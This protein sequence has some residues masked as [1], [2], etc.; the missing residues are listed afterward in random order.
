MKKKIGVRIILVAVLLNLAACNNKKDGFDSSEKPPAGSFAYSDSNKASNYFDCDKNY[1]YY[2]EIDD[3]TMVTVFYK[4]KISSKE[5]KAEKIAEFQP[6]Q[7]ERY[8]F[9]TV[10]DYSLTVYKEYIVFFHREKRTLYKMTKDGKDFSP[11]FKEGE[12]IANGSCKIVNGRL[13]F[14]NMPDKNKENAFLY[15][16]DL[17]CM[18]VDDILAGNMPS[19]ENRVKTEESDAFYLYNYA[20]QNDKV[21]TYYSTESPKNPLALKKLYADGT[22]VLEYYGSCIVTHQYIFYIDFEADDRYTFWRCNLDGSNKKKITVF[23][24]ENMLYSSFVNYDKNSVY[25]EFRDMS[26]SDSTLYRIS[27]DGEK[28]YEYEETFGGVSHVD[29]YGNK[30][31]ASKFEDKKLFMLAHKDGT[32]LMR[33]N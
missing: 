17:Y 8:K 23:E 25:F 11:L 30:L 29:I 14:R 9:A 13:L 12:W 22:L 26:D 6:Y 18:K 21:Y 2:Y 5:S 15:E 4:V 1:I 28:L 10:G 20:L 32:G 16:G 24:N 3:D 27:T 19:E 33:L 31:F 7:E